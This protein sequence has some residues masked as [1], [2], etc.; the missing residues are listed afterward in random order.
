MS[1]S[2]LYDD[3]VSCLSVMTEMQVAE[4]LSFVEDAYRMKGGIIG[5]RSALKT[6]SARRIR[7]RMVADMIAGAVFPPVVLGLIVDNAQLHRWVS[8]VDSDTIVSEVQSIDRKYISIIDGMQRTTAL[9]DAVGINE[10]IRENNLRVE[11]WISSNQESLIYRMLVL[12][13]GQIPWDVKHQVAVVFDSLIDAV[14]ENTSVGRILQQTGERRF[15]AGEYRAAEIAE[16]YVAFGSRKINIDTQE[17]LADEF[18]KIDI[19]DAISDEDYAR[20]FYKTLDLLVRVDEIFSRFKR[21]TDEKTNTGRRIFDKQTARIGF[22]VS[23]AVQVFGRAGADRTGEEKEVHFREFTLMS[24]AFI[25][26]IN[27]LNNAELG[28][29][30]RIDV[31][32]ELLQKKVTQVGRYERNLFYEAF[33][34]LIDEKFEVK[35]MEQCWRASM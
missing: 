8:G 5:Q 29:F 9:L 4:Y 20:Y 14:R 19:V 12:N 26:R 15:N 3:R 33:K 31:L 17:Y 6:T 18:S 30:L 7:E 10:S 13:A 35:T 23:I 1:N 24:E 22:V 28:D 25:D 21:L 2:V 34:V 27:W 32:D 16:L 11:F